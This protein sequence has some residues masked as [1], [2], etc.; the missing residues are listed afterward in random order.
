MLFLFSPVM[1]LFLMKEEQ[2]VRCVISYFIKKENEIITMHLENPVEQ[3]FALPKVLNDSLF[4]D[5]VEP[6]YML[7]AV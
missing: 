4:S 2:F 6:L 7:P 5:N 3:H 1:D